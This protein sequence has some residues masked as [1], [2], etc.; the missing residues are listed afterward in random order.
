MVTL[1]WTA[2]ATAS[3]YNVYRSTTTNGQAAPPLATNLNAPA[4]VDSPVT[5]G[6]TYFYKVTAVN[7]FGESERSTEA[8]ASPMGTA[9]PPPPP[10]PSG[11]PALSST[12]RFLRQA[13]WG[14]R[15]GDIERVRS[16]G[17]DGFFAE[18]LGAPRSQYP[19]ALFDQSV[20]A[21]QEQFMANA[22]T[23][24]DQLRQRVAWALHK[25]WVVSAIQIDQTRAHPPLLPDPPESRAFGNYKDLMKDITLNPAMGRYLNMVNN[26][27]QAITGAPANENYAREL[28]QLFTWGTV[29]LNQNGTPEGGRAD[30]HL[31]RSRREGAGPRLHGLDLR[32]RQPGDHSARACSR[33]ISCLPMEPVAR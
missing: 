18:Q 22:L 6:V 31:H 5:N 15:P 32:R 12:F 11:D 10:P 24:Q 19:A 26:R 13:T 7:A 25:I 27:S 14:P 17:T 21:A 28:L 2:V 29:K 20:E 33:R 23:G 8:S 4:F 3:S 9:P 16:L 1:S 30:A